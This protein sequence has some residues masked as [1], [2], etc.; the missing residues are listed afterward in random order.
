MAWVVIPNVPN[1]EYNNAPEDPGVDSPYRALWL[2]QTN[3]IRTKTH[4]DHSDLVYT[5]VRMV[6]DTTDATRGE[7]SK[8]WCDAQGSEDNIE[9]DMILVFRTTGANQEVRVGAARYYDGGWVDYDA[10]IDWGDGTTTSVTG[11]IVDNAGLVH[12]FASAGDHTVRVSGPSFHNVNFSPGSQTHGTS[13]GGNTEAQTDKL[14]HVLNL[15]DIGHRKLYGAFRRTRRLQSFTAGHTDLSNCSSLRSFF[16]YRTWNT[17]PPQLTVD[18][19][20]MDLS[21]LIG[22]KRMNDFFAKVGG[23]TIINMTNINTTGVLEMYHMFSH[24]SGGNSPEVTTIDVRPLNT[25]SVTNMSGMF[26]D[27]RS[28]H[29]IVGIED[30]DVSSNQWFSSMFAQS[31][32]THTGGA[33]T[34]LDLSSWV[35]QSASAQYYSYMFDRSFNLTDIIGIENINVT[36]LRNTSSLTRILGDGSTGVTLP[37]SRYDQLLINLAAQTK[38]QSTQTAH[39]G[40]SKYTAGGAAEAARTSLINNDGYA[41]SDGG[42]V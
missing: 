5:D 17:N 27:N 30:M 4:L 41:I 12:T 28:L 10:S 37:T 38:N 35:W 29:T 23:N 22:I 20:G 2:K 31:G 6:G 36:N 19:S 24:M 16:E 1:W 33:M 40:S 15:G 21:V 13:M 14:I 7:M 34:S 9:T 25:S 18:L 39:F 3:G 32:N 26:Y 11:D 42:A 8:S